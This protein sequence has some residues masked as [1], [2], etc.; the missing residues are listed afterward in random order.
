MA[1]WPI[2]GLDS[3]QRRPVCIKAV[4]PFTHNLLVY[5]NHRLP[6]RSFQGIS[7]SSSLLLLS[8]NAFI[9]STPASEM[10]VKCSNIRLAHHFFPSPPTFDF[11]LILCS[12]VFF[13]F[14]T[15]WSEC[16]GVKL[17][18]RDFYCTF[19]NSGEL[20][21]PLFLCIGLQ[22]HLTIAIISL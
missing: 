1:I 15:L 14:F 8:F 22:K 5:G 21:W 10:Y 2:K 11:S 19:F 7:C 20:W 4:I 12:D 13:F 16:E 9:M 6:K 3:A 17:I 18:S